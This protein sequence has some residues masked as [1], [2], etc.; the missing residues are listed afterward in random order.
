MSTS[1]LSNEQH[2]R[3]SR[4]EWLKSIL[5]LPVI[6]LV[7]IAGLSLV[8][9]LYENQN[10]TSEPVASPTPTRDVAPTHSVSPTAVADEETLTRLHQISLSL[11]IAQAEQAI[12]HAS[13]AAREWHRVRAETRTNEAGRQLATDSEL[14]TQF[15]ALENLDRSNDSLSQLQSSLNELAE[16]AETI[17]EQSLIESVKTRVV[18]IEERAKQL[19]ANY[20]GYRQALSRLLIQAAA[21][22]A[23]SN[24]SC[25][26]NRDSG[27]DP[28]RRTPITNRA[29]G[30]EIESRH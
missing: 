30:H 12:N 6:V 18:A 25:P 22:P 21:L 17:V 11:E 23:S 4:R 7:F 3:V 29:I 26:E 9:T 27:T 1:N 24:Y 19:N 15:I 10:D 14:L 20:Q 16:E 8:L 13:D 2:K 28:A 5:L